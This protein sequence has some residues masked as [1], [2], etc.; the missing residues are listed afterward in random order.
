MLNDE[1]PKS[2]EEV[3]LQAQ[4]EVTEISSNPF[5]DKK[6]VSKAGIFAAVIILLVIGGVAVFAARKSKTNSTDSVQASPTLGASMTPGQGSQG[7]AVPPSGAISD[8]DN[9]LPSCGAN[10][11]LHTVPLADD[12]LLDVSPLGNINP[13]GHTVPSDHIGLGLTVVT[14][15]SSDTNQ[16]GNAKS[17]TIQASV[18]APADITIFK[19]H[20]QTVTENGKSNSDYSIFYHPCRE[21]TMYNNHI[22]VLNTDL[23]SFM[24]AH[25]SEATCQTQ[26]NTGST[27]N[28]F[29]DYAIT[30]KAKEGAVLGTAGGAGQATV[31]IDYGLY[32][33]RTTPLAYLN[34]ELAKTAQ[35]TE[36][37]HSA[38]PIDYYPA[39]IQAMLYAKLDQTGT[40]SDHPSCGTIMQDKAGTVQGNWYVKGSA[41]ENWPTVFAVLHNSTD[42]SVGVVSIGGTIADPG[43]IRFNVAKTGT[44]NLEPSLTQAGTLYCYTT[45]IAGP[46]GTVSATNQ[47]LLQLSADGTLQAEDQAGNCTGSLAFKSPTTYTR[48]A[49]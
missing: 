43:M 37:L 11:L 22:P 6:S 48:N 25:K 4:S 24:T 10:P 21:V 27:T 19:I 45:N 23:M 32:D 36:I 44:T 9:T 17:T 47:V 7:V 5:S 20:A 49:H 33:T 8:V 29:C 34:T 1:S 46:N 3:P 12:H 38:C 30:Y 26:A 31:G 15:P 2:A 40:K 42:A 28:E 39:D 13:P 41:L 35:S 16:P 18:F 14:T